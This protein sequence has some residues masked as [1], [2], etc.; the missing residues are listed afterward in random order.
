MALVESFGLPQ[1]GLGPNARVNNADP[2]L[3]WIRI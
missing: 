2:F 1:Q 3:H